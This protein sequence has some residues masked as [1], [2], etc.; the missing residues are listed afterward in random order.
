MSYPGSGLV[1][2]VFNLCFIALVALIV[3]RPRLYV[4]TFLAAFLALGFWVKVIVHAIWAP[5]FVEPVGDFSSTPAEWDDA[6][7]ASS[8]GAVGLI[9]ARLGHLWHA[10]RK[11]ERPDDAGGAAPQW[12]IRWR[13]SIWILTILIVIGVNAANLQF[14]FFQIGVKPRLILPMR[15]HVLLGWLVNIGLAL[16]VASLVWWDYK[17]RRSLGRNLLLPIGESL[18]S[19]TSSFSRLNFLLHAV[20]YALVIF[21]RRNELAGLFKR[22]GLAIVIV[23]LCLFAAS[24]VAVFGLREIRYYE[25]TQ[26]NLLHTMATQMPLLLVHRWVGL[27]GVLTVGAAPNRGTELFL[28]ALT[29]NPKLGDRSLFQRV[30]KANVRY[31]MESE[32]LV[33]L[34]NAGP[35]AVLLFSGSLAMVMAGMALI[36]LVLFLTEKVAGR[37]TGNPLLLAVS[38][39]AL[40]NVVSQTTFFYLT[41]IFLGQIWVAVV[42]LAILQRLDFCNFREGR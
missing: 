32:T 33:F 9:A 42:F 16:W 1:F 25:P 17:Q 34:S 41:L 7:L 13:R 5:G 19:A 12:F 36:G 21:E 26:R 28:A 27:E 20:P 23:A 10:R 39:A 8:C 18:F 37:L 14:A 35:V 31:T 2:A 24:V 38:G 40:A 6:L 11:R 4:Y 22:R 30:A 29:E 15:L 3:P